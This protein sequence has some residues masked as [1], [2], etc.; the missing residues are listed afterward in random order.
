MS[1][2]QLLFHRGLR[3]VSGSR[4]FNSGSGTFVVPLFNSLT[5]E[6]WGAGA[7]ASGFDCNGSPFPGSWVGGNSGGDSTIDSLGLF[8]G[9]GKASTD[10]KA[11]PSGGSAHGGSTNTG[12]S[13][14]ALGKQ[15]TAFSTWTAGNGGAGANGGSGGIGATYTIPS[16]NPP[17]SPVVS[18]G[19]AGNDQGGGVGGN[20]YYCGGTQ[21]PNAG[22]KATSASGAGGAYC[23]RIYLASALVVKYLDELDY[24]V[25]SP[26]DPFNIP[27]VVTGN[28]FG[29]DPGRGKIK[30]TWS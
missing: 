30:F 8:A 2:Q 11:A 29:F 25:G 4:T 10:G 15:E 24:V 6:L 22:G 18:F 16:V 12:G 14:G 28:S 9:G 26:G 5:I 13:A 7:T 17:G 1:I 27:V 23:K 21:P 19:T 3:V 20:A